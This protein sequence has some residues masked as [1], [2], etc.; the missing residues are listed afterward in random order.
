MIDRLLAPSPSRRPAWP[1]ADGDV[2]PIG[3]PDEDEGYGDDD[4][5]DEDD[6]EEDDDEEPWQVRLRGSAPDGGFIGLV[7]AKAG[8]V[9]SCLSSDTRA[10]ER[11]GWIPA[12]AGMT[13]GGD[14]GGRG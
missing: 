8:V 9:T 2:V 4:E 14:D 11:H 1:G 5:D 13:A 6:E 12:F 3:D 7:P 10:W